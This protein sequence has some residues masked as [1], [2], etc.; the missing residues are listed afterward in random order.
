MTVLFYG[1]EDYRIKVILD[2]VKTTLYNSNIQIG[3]I[4]WW[5]LTPDQVNLNKIEK[6]IDEQDVCFF[7]SIEIYHCL[8]HKSQISSY[9]QDTILLCNSK[10]NVYFIRYSEESNNFS[11]DFDI[12]RTFHLPWFCKQQFFINENI[13]L[14]YDYRSKKY[15]FNYLAGSRKNIRTQIYQAVADNP[16]IYSTYYGHP[17]LRKFSHK[18]LED[19]T[20]SQMLEVQDVFRNKLNTM[21]SL[22]LNKVDFAFSH[23]AP[24][25]IYNDTHFDIVCETQTDNGLFFSTEKTAKP[26]LYGRFFVW[27]TSYGFRNYLNSFGFRFNTFPNFGDNIVDPIDRICCFKDFI[28]SIS[29][30]ENKILDIYELTKEDRKHNREHIINMLSNHNSMLSDWMS[31]ILSSC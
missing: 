30:N 5:L 7:L 20:I 24:V 15:T 2:S 13:L 29:G 21:V 16:N 10:K 3:V 26:L 9:I 22:T 11:V 8:A 19:P 14:D 28:E 23:V 12:T 27:F 4:N 31:K 18:D 6:F 1:Q 25:S 17:Y